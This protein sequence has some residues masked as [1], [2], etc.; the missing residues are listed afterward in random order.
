MARAEED[1]AAGEQPDSDAAATFAA[2]KSWVRQRVSSAFRLTHGTPMPPD[3]LTA[4]MV[5][6]ASATAAAVFA[7]QHLEHVI[8]FALNDMCLRLESSR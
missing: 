8:A 2:A 1:A 7:R 6:A 5:R 3:L 4:V